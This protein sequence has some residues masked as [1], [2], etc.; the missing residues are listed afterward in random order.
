MCIVLA[1]LMR[2]VMQMT[3]DLGEL[4]G[5]TVQFCN[6]GVMRRNYRV[7]ARMMRAVGATTVAIHRGHRAREEAEP[8]QSLAVRRTAGGQGADERSHTGC[9]KWNRSCHRNSP[10]EKGLVRVPLEHT[11]CQRSKDGVCHRVQWEMREYARLELDAKCCRID[12]PSVIVM[13]ARRF[14]PQRL[15]CVTMC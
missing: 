10:K 2:V 9:E 15:S 13:T 8:D 1:Q 6:T 7:T 3:C 12:L 11:A 14:I 4:I 5:L